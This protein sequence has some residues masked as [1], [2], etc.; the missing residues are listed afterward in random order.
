MENMLK[1]RKE[2]PRANFINSELIKKSIK[3]IDIAKDLKMH[4]NSVNFWIHGK[5]TSERITEWFRQKFGES[6]LKKLEIS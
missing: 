5:L 1:Q 4:K 3:Q 6:F 2:N